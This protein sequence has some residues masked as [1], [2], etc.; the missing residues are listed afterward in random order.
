MQAI[1]HSYSSVKSGEKYAPD[2]YSYSNIWLFKCKNTYTS[3]IIIYI[4]IH[5][6]YIY[7]YNIQMYLACILVD[8]Y[9][10]CLGLPDYGF[11]LI[12]YRLMPS[13]LDTSTLEVA[14]LIIIIIL[15]VRIQTGIFHTTIKKE[16]FCN[17][18]ILTIVKLVTD[19]FNLH[20]HFLNTRY[21]I[22][23]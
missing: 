7:I 21:V 2:N 3:I 8:W 19:F 12:H 9:S 13:A 14:I 1:C 6:I 15:Q 16:M 20:N 23:S 11:I 10:R 17:R 22:Q 18:L 5:C 4:Y